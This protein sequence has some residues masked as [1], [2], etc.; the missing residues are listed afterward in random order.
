MRPWQQQSSNMSRQLV[1]R[2]KAIGS[3]GERN[4]RGILRP[5]FPDIDLGPPYH[6]TKDHTNTGDWHIESKK[7][8]TWNIKDVVKAME[9]RVPEDE[10]WA[11]MYEDRDRR[12]KENPSGVYAIVPA[13]WF[14]EL[15]AAYEALT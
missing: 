1:P 11:I 14:V 5:V 12:K 8:N 2:S 10:P 6:P 4:H 3:S 15:L 9:Q 13:E 7:R